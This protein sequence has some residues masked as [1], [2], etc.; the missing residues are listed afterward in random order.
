VRQLFL[1]SPERALSCRPCALQ[2]TQ[3]Q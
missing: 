2:T 3:L 1:S